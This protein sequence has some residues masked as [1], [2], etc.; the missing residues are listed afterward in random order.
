MDVLF[1][2]AGKIEYLVHNS[3]FD[4]MDTTLALIYFFYQYYLCI[5]S[6]MFLKCLKLVKTHIVVYHAITRDSKWYSNEIK[7][8]K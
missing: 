5:S 4:T 2:K 1:F 7:S 8:L 6:Y 3:K